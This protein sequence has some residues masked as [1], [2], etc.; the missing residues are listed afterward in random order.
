MTSLQILAL[1]A[2]VLAAAAAFL[3]TWRLHA[4][5]PAAVAL[6]MLATVNVVAAPIGAALPPSV[7]PWQGWSRVLVYLDGALN[8]ATCATIAGLAIAVAVS[9]GHRRRA[10]LFVVGVWAVAS[11]VLA[12]LYPSPLVRGEGLQ[13]AYL[14]ADLIGLFVSTVALITWARAVKRSHRSAAMVALALVLLDFAILLTPVSP[15]RASVIGASFDGVQFFIMVS[16][17]SLAAAQVI[18]WRFFAG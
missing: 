12:A 14:A 1:A 2:Q 8:V 5:G 17:A 7:E 3:L 6:A 15:W 11:V 10:V 4:H 16:F 13:R 9:P 18:A